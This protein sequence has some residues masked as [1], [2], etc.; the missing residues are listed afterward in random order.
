MGA[1]LKDEAVQHPLVPL[2]L[3]V[4]DNRHFVT[5]AVDLFE[6]K[7]YPSVGAEDPGIAMDLVR[8][9]AFDVVLLD[10]RMPGVDGMVLSRLIHRVRPRTAILLMSALRL[11]ELVRTF[12]D[13]EACAV[14]RSHRDLDCVLSDSLRGAR[15]TR[16]YFVVDKD[17]VLG[18]RVPEILDRKGVPFFR[19]PDVRSAARCLKEHPGWGLIV[20]DDAMP[21][22]NGLM[23]YLELRE[24]YPHAEVLAVTAPVEDPGD[25]AACALQRGV[26]GALG[27]PLDLKKTARII[28]TIVKARK[29][30]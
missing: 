8:S 29:R 10:I 9:I 1:Q 27:K 17:R 13:E 6:E 2:I 25:I 30:R 12:L 11:E 22:V 7:G 4:D 18:T 15:A 28:D 21:P 19:V 23:A 16:F 26:Y 20:L 3:I 24:E 5:T 14:I